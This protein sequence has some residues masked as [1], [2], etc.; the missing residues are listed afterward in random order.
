[1][2]SPTAP[3]PLHD[4]AGI[5]RFFSRTCFQHAS[6]PS[7][8]TPGCLV[9][10]HMRNSPA[11]FTYR[12]AMLV[13]HHGVYP[14]PTNYFWPPLRK[15]S[16]SKLFR[17]VSVAIWRVVSALSVVSRTLVLNFR[18]P[19]LLSRALLYIAWIG[20]HTSA[21]F[22]LVRSFTGGLLMCFGSKRIASKTGFLSR[23]NGAHGNGFPVETFEAPC[24]SSGYSSVFLPDLLYF[25]E[26]CPWD[27]WNCHGSSPSVGATWYEN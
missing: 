26:T 10:V 5:H 18:A 15:H 14:S 3:F 16:A 2:N 7:G 13:A 19:S 22:V 24:T 9:V 6:T 11:L 1:M 4:K 27:D 8:R 23:S 21:W 17:V 12:A 25:F 20:A